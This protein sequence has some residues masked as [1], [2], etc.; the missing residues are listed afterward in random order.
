[1]LTRL[2]IITVGLSAMFAFMAGA[3]RAL[4]EDAESLSFLPADAPMVMALD[5]D[6]L[7]AYMTDVAEGWREADQA[8][9]RQ[10]LEILSEMLTREASKPDVLAFFNRL[11]GVQAF[12]MSATGG[13]PTMIFAAEN[14]ADGSILGYYTGA[15]IVEARYKSVLQEMTNAL[16]SYYHRAVE[17]AETGETIA[18]NSYPESIE[19]LIQ[20][21]YL[22]EM[23]INPFTGEPIQVVDSMEDGSL[24]DIYYEPLDV[25]AR[26]A[27][28]SASGMD[29]VVNVQGVYDN[30]SL[31]SFHVGGIMTS[32]G[33]QKSFEPYDDITGNLRRFGRNYD[34]T[35]MGFTVETSGDWTYV[36][37]PD[38][39]Y[40]FAFGDGFLIFE[41]DIATLREMVGRYETGD[42]FRFD[43][44]RD[45]N[46]DGA[47]FRC[48][49]D[50][51]AFAEMMLGASMEEMQREMGA[52]PMEMEGFMTGMFDSIGLDAISSQHT[53]CR[54]RF[55][56][57]EMARWVELSGESADS[58][59]GTMLSTEPQVLMT[60]E[61]GPF[62]II[63]EMAWANPGRYMH[64][65]IDYLME[66]VFP[67]MMEEM[68]G[69][70]PGDA[71]DPGEMLRMFGLGGIESMD[72]GEQVLVLLTGPA[73]RGD[74]LYLPGLVTILKTD[75]E[76]LG[77]LAVGVM[78]T[79]SLMIPDLPI[80]QEDFGDENAVT[81]VIEDENFPLTPTIAW[82]DGWMVKSLWREDAL[83]A[84]ET[85]R[86]G[87]MLM[88]DG[89]E[90]A[91]M[92]LHVHGQELLRGIADV[93]YAMPE[94][95][96]APAAAI[97][98]ILA[99]LSEPEDRI[100]S[101]MVGHDG[102]FETRCMMSIGLC[103]DLLPLL[104]YV[105]KG[106]E[107]RW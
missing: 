61:G 1:M 68:M 95:E 104:A 77:Y 103:E 30:Y 33:R 36:A 51:D 47:F 43:P 35:D 28:Q 82:T 11:S 71:M 69:E 87:T 92:R 102:Y 46:T 106:F 59:I 6:G 70:M 17:D 75:S 80:H 96:I 21:G 9:F 18:P 39:D 62:E 86:M 24:G 34:W 53:A 99:R 84:I 60:A 3:T 56:D 66:F 44:P 5:M 72:F 26:Y 22:E 88:P 32:R 10:S 100:Y 38:R 16:R 90:P 8:R 57:I 31:V 2:M 52:M 37:P 89:M 42:G 19:M 85:L 27:R 65:Y 63:G 67:M 98:E 48:Q 97:L 107:Y 12:S 58:F 49:T 40:A 41:S 81:W 54:L 101:E 94:G 14:E 76:D 7:R 55:G 79:L 4:D 83:T 13:I 93:V 25:H 105:V 74:G 20:S 64:A 50:I 73:D 15:Y 29:E 91:N 23:P 45:F 78:D